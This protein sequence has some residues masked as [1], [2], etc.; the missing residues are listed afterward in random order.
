MNFEDTDFRY[1]FL[2]PENPFD[3]KLVS[4]FL[5]QNGY[6]YLAEDVDLTVIL[7]NLNDELIGTGSFKN[8]TLKYVVVAPKFRDTTAFPLI[9]SY[10]SFKIL[11]DHKRCFVFT[12]PETAVMFEGLGFK[13]ITRAEPLY[14]VLEFG[15]ESI[16]D[17]QENLKSYR[18]KTKT[19]NV[20]SI[21]VNCNPFT[22]GHQYL[23][24][25]AASENEILYLF[26]VEEDL[27]IFPYEVRLGIVKKGIAHLD[28]VVIIPT[29]PYIVS[30]GIFPNYFLKLESSNL[31]SEKQAEVD[32]KIFAKYVVPTLGIT[33]R[34]VGTETY[35]T[36]TRA[37][38]EAMK[39]ILPDAGCELIEVDRKTIGLVSKGDGKNC[40]SA[41]KVRLAMKEDRIED[42][43]EFL[44]QVTQDFLLSP[45]SKEIWDKL[46][47]KKQR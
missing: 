22:L 39:K 7:Y 26:I 24:E 15:Y 42:M 37:Y 8:Q 43:L 28:N 31:I 30:G 17:Y 46:K 25:K 4:G 3:V 19:E 9:V 47:V 29:G 10:L 16:N 20:A 23:I 33:K 32:I 11:K 41:S 35:C 21:V 6:D 13:E 34:Y 18:A 45:E 44:P 12:K 5:T 38:N 27:S 2:D 36:T 40:I 14:S 1:E